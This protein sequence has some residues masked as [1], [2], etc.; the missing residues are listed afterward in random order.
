MREATVAAVVDAYLERPISIKNPGQTLS[1]G[2]LAQDKPEKLV[3]L[4]H[5]VH[6]TVAA[7]SQGGDI[8]AGCVAV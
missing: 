8:T 4:S 3:I 7:G 1:A 5:R 2:A 6:Q